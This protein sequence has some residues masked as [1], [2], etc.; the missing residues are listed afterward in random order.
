MKIHLQI[1][2]SLILKLP[3]DY[4]W[5][6]SDWAKS[7]D[8]SSNQIKVVDHVT[9]VPVNRHRA[10]ANSRKYRKGRKPVTDPKVTYCGC[11]PLYSDTTFIGPQLPCNTRC[12]RSRD[13]IIQ[14][15]WKPKTSCDVTTKQPT[16]VNRAWKSALD[17][18][19][20]KHNWEEFCGFRTRWWW[21]L[22]ATSWLSAI[23]ALQ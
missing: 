2:Q 19:L 12:C 3:T 7:T 9:N 6:V 21:S 16:L 23:I 8:P 18:R 15:R 11:G 14:Q 20:I 13:V 10:T 17:I 1:V 4:T 5:D 22:P